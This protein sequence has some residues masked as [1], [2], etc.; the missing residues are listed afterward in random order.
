MSAVSV[1]LRAYARSPFLWSGLLCLLFASIFVPLGA[2]DLLDSNRLTRDG[3]ETSA[4]VTD[5][6]IHTSRRS[7]GGTRT[8]YSL[9]LRFTDAQGV[10]HLTRLPVSQDIYHR[11]GIGSRMALRYVAADP[12]IAEVEPGATLRDGALMGGIG[13]AMLLVALMCG[14]IF[15]RTTAAMRRA[16]RDGARRLAQ[17]VAHHRVGKQHARTF[18]AEWSDGLT[19]G[20]TRTLREAN[21]PAIG[22]QIP[23]YVDPRTGRGWWEGDIQ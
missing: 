13:A 6:D 1:S 11:N 17:V 2:I 21:L 4:I 16:V 10:Q 7:N 5:H 23:V 12:T 3:V 9:T 20:K 18:T 22:S 15:L 19:I 8:S 14:A